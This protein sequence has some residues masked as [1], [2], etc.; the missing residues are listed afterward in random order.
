MYMHKW[1][2]KKLRDPGF[3]G[4]QGG[5]RGEVRAELR[6][7]ETQKGGGHHREGEKWRVY[8]G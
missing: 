6:S 5:G 3:S 1:K 2:A 4:T 7:G 8:A